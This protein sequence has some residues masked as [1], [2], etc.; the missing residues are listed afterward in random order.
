MVAGVS[1]VKRPDHLSFKRGDRYVVIFPGGY[2]GVGE[3]LDGQ[4]FGTDGRFPANTL[5]T[6]RAKT[7]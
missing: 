4:I 3:R 2:R 5:L 1:H 6:K 7:A